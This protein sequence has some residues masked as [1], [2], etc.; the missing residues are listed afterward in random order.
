[1]KRFALTLAAMVLIS[2]VWANIFVKGSLGYGLGT[3]K[4]LLEEAY[5]LSNTKNIYGSFGGNLGLTLGAGL[6]L[7][8]HIEFGADL[9]YQH[10]RSVTASSTYYDK[11]YT[12]RLIMLSPF[13]T[14]RTLIEDNI[15]P[16]AKLGVFTGLPLTKVDV[17]SQVKKFRGGLPFGF[18]GA[19]GLNF[20]AMDNMK[21]FAEI[22]N[23]SMIYKPTK[24]KEPNGTVVR[25]K[26]ELPYSA[27][28]GEEMSHHFF[29]FGALG[30]NIGI[31]IEL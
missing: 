1:M 22:A 11:I 25:F 10:G 18:N 20:N 6:E 31:K 21:F 5:T 17:N 9:G 13:L 14:F 26:D 4:L 24:R 7:N 16:Y 29:S 8:K 23:Q 27:P 12:G 30:I 15:T 3:Q 28:S 19:L 2:S